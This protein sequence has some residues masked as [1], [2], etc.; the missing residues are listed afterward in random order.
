MATVSRKILKPHS[1][2]EGNQTYLIRLP[3][4]YDGNGSTIGAAL[5]IKK[6]A[7]NYEPKAGDISIS[8]CEGQKQGKLVKMR[9]SY[10]QGT[11]KK[12]S[13]ITCPVDKAATAVT[14]ILSKNFEGNNIVGAG[15]PR[16]RR[17]G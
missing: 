9:I 13:I 2:T 1:F 15:F 8:V 3:D 12:N 14:Q 5:G 17:R 10:L 16:R 4:I 11:K 6:L 7:D